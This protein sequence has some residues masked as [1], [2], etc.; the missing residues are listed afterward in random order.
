MDNFKVKVSRVREIDTK[1]HDTN[2]NGAVI[3]GLGITWFDT[4]GNSNHKWSLLQPITRC[5]P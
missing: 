1:F 2:N 4:L 3:D 5:E